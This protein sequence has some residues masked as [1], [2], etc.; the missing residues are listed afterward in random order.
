M[1]NDI[2]M[3]QA[4]EE[5]FDRQLETLVSKNYPALAGMS[6]EKFIEHIEPLRGLLPKASASTEDAIPFVIVVKHEL[7]STVPAVERF[8]VRH[9]AGWTDMADEIDSYKPIEGSTYPRRPPTCSSTST[10]VGKRSTCG[11]TTRCRSSPV[12]GGPR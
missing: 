10:P 3:A 4:V 5:E 1:T 2:G 11:P 7:V 8:L 6:L 9:K 12:P